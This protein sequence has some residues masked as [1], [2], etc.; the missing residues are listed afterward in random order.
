MQTVFVFAAVEGSGGCAAEVR[1][2]R[3]ECFLDIKTQKVGAMGMLRLQRCARERG[4]EGAR[5]RV[6]RQRDGH[7]CASE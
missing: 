5:A 2:G 3:Y 1:L 4:G 6:A 7:A